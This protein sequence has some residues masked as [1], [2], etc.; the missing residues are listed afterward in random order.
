MEFIMFNKLMKDINKIIK[1]LITS[2]EIF[3]PFF[4]KEK[5]DKIKNEILKKSI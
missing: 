3:K 4:Y 1:Q 5:S 2:K